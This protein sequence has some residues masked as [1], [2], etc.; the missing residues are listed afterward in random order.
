MCGIAGFVPCTPH[1]LDER[2]TL[3]AML[4][5]VAHRGPEGTRI[6]FDRGVA[7]GHC[8]LGFVSIG[9]NLQ[10]RVSA[11]GRTAVVFNGE[12]YNRRDLVRQLDRREDDALTDTEVV[13]ELYERHGVQCLAML[14]G[15]FAIALHDFAAERTVLARDRFGKKPL[16]FFTS[17]GT[18]AFASE[19]R[20]LL[21]HP[22]CPRGVDVRSLARYLVFNACVAP[23]TLVDGVRKVRAGTYLTW[24][25]GSLA[26]H[27]Y[28]QMAAPARDGAGSMN[29]WA[30]KLDASLTEA[31][32]TRLAAD[33]PLGTFLS[34]GV[35]S[36][37]VT[38]MAARTSPVPLHAFSV[39]F[40]DPSFDETSYAARV[41]AATGVQHHVL[42]VSRADLAA[43]VERQYGEVDEP[44]ADPSLAPALLLAAHAASSV[45]G[46]LT[47][48]G[49]DELFLGYR[50]F[51]ALAVLDPIERLAGAG[52][53]RKVLARAGAGPARHSN[54]PASLIGALLSRAVGV[55]AER[56]WYEATGAWQPARFAE[57]L[58]PDV[59]ASLR[60]D[61]VYDELDGFIA[62]SGAGRA[63]AMTRA[64]YGMTCHYLRD[65]ILAKLDRATMRNGIEARCPFLDPDVVEIVA[66]APRPLLMR[67]LDTKRVIKA[68]ARRY[69]PRD[70]VDRRKQGFRAPI[71][72]LLAHELRP[73]MLDLLS[74]EALRAHD[75]FD[76][77]AVQTLVDDHLAGRRD[78]QKALWSLVCFQAWH[79]G[80]SA[81]A[82]PAAAW[83]G[84]AS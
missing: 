54:M 33:V 24:R 6:L 39:G 55:A 81:A 10:P 44:I 82:R 43:V 72:S 60:D 17:R 36:S 35:D 66:Q 75:L 40:D 20:A 13:L 52:P 51:Q 53:L 9:A 18:L 37:L 2:R 48:D 49:A 30:D 4:A 57:L 11:S 15:M 21:A 12:I 42:R 69:L 25:A 22:A 46:V 63:D 28:W 47:G 45:K 73:Y 84:A 8:A 31:V 74:R 5:T 38:A 70:I 62:R 79:A 64:Q 65:V 29:E 7:L 77:R 71:A 83:V 78:H 59:A 58:A 23:R 61:D 34:G 14:R 19:L 56:R 67:R 16:Y 3:T 80:V 32:R 26:E 27:Q 76:V 1:N 68:V 50:F 41:A